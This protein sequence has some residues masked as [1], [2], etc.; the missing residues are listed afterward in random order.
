MDIKQLVDASLEDAI[1]AAQ[2]LG[3]L[4]GFNLKSLRGVIACVKWAVKH[5][6]EIQGLTGPEKNLFVVELVIKVTKLPFWL[7]PIARS[8]LPFVV[9]AVVDALK[10][11]FGK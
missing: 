11:K 9:D 6:Q 7:E 4:K 10:D 3:R 8:F 1:K 2:E 5:A